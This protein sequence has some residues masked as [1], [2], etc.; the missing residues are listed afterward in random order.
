M[1]FLNIVLKSLMNIEINVW[2]TFITEEQK[3]ED[4]LIGRIFLVFVEFLTGFIITTEFQLLDLVI[5]VGLRAIVRIIFETP[6]SESDV[7]TNSI[8]H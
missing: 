6:D 3:N 7:F 8:I 2:L 5:S 1:L 4:L